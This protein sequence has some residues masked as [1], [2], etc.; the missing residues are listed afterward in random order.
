MSP[1]MVLLIVLLSDIDPYVVI[2]MKK[3]NLKKKPNQIQ[4]V[5]SSIVSGRTQEGCSVYAYLVCFFN[6]NF[7]NII[8]ID[9]PSR[10]SQ[11]SRENDCKLKN[12]KSIVIKTFE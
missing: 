2:S 10:F 11:Y 6:F 8:L 9:F 5:S 12:K 3:E 7:I 1:M 4:L